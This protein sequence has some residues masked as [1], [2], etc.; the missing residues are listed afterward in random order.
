MI[1]RL[2]FV[3]ALFLVPIELL[4]QPIP[5]IAEPPGAIRQDLNQRGTVDRV[6]LWPIRW[7]NGAAV[8][9]IVQ[10]AFWT[11]GNSVSIEH[12]I[13]IAQENTYIPADVVTFEGAIREV[14]QEGHVIQLEIVFHQF[15]DSRCWPTG[16]RSVILLP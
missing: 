7:N 15:G 1:W 5:E 3:A 2:G 9:F 6:R 11:G 8:D 10:T 14:H 13:Y 16:E 12:R 4:A